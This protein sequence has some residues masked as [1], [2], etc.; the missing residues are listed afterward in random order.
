[1]QFTI[2]NLK[3]YFIGKNEVSSKMVTNDSVVENT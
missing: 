2:L 1:M 3:R